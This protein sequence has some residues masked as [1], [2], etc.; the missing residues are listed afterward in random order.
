MEDLR[1]KVDDPADARRILHW[2]DDSF[3]HHA[4]HTDRV[5]VSERAEEIIRSLIPIVEREYPADMAV[6]RLKDRLGGESA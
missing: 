4:Q 6:M 3:R 5:E 2:A 1:T